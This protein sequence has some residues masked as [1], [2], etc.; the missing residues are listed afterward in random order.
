MLRPGLRQGRALAYLSSF[1][2]DGTPRVGFVK[3]VHF[4]AEVEAEPA[5]LR[6][7]VEE[8]RERDEEGLPLWAD[9]LGRRE[10]ASAADLTG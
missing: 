1:P 2:L 5:L 6:L 10:I 7:S 3:V 9:W 8:A 4:A